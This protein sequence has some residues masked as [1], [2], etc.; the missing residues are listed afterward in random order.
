MARRSK[1]HAIYSVGKERAIATAEAHSRLRG[2]SWW[3]LVY[4]AGM[5]RIE[6]HRRG[7]WRPTGYLSLIPLVLL[8]PVPCY[9]D[10]GG[11]TSGRLD[12]RSRDS[13]Y[14]SAWR[15]LSATANG[16]STGA[17]RDSA[18][19]TL[20]VLGRMLYVSRMER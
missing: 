10:L 2:H 13:G 1:L 6:L 19:R 12:S 9:W 15:S 14:P 17:S 11:L 3:Y 16:V 8:R 4:C 7:F 18:R 5:W 20:G